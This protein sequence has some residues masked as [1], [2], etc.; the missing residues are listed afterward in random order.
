MLNEKNPVSACRTLSGLEKVVVRTATVAF[1]YSGEAEIATNGPLELKKS[2][3][4]LSSHPGL[5]NNWV[6]RNDSI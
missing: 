2:L 5:L 6:P 4:D 3:A 1:E